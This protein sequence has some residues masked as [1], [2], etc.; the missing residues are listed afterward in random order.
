MK[1]LIWTLQSRPWCSRKSLDFGSLV[2]HVSNK[3]I[4]D[5]TVW[6]CFQS[7]ENQ[8]VVFAFW[9]SLRILQPHGL[10]KFCTEVCWGFGS[11]MRQPRLAEGGSLRRILACT[12]CN[13]IAKWIRL[14]NFV[15]DSLP[16]SS[17][18]HDKANNVKT[19]WKNAVAKKNSTES[20][21]ANWLPHWLID[22]ASERALTRAT[23]WLKPNVEELWYL[24]CHWCHKWMPR[25]GVVH[26]VHSGTPWFESEPRAID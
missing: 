22:Y 6:S 11:R 12:N 20:A 17:E 14:L 3:A 24:G 7:S 15:V 26:E 16:P 4:N 18:F 21:E 5:S 10:Q 8:I 19:T 25:T 2:S 1:A 9:K 23:A 13:M